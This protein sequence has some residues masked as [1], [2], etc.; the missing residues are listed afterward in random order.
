[1]Q[2]GVD[3]YPKQGFKRMG[4]LAAFSGGNHLAFFLR[5]KNLFRITP[6]MEF[7]PA[8]HRGQ[9]MQCNLRIGPEIPILR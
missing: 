8:L 7:F 9:G 5:I 2:R 1:M 4:T 3:A 6:Q